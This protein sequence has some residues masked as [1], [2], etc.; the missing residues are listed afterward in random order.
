MFAALMF[1]APWSTV[2]SVPDPVDAGGDGIA[3]EAMGIAKRT[4]RMQSVFFMASPLFGHEG[5]VH[6]H[7]GACYVVVRPNYRPV[8]PH[9]RVSVRSGPDIHHLGDSCT[10]IR[11]ETSCHVEPVS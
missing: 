11:Q 3:H 2:Q 10:A 1:V 6:D 9:N 5:Q 8:A 7:R 4:N